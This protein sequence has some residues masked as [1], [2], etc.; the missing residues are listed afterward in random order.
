MNI[1]RLLAIALL[2]TPAAVFSVAQGCATEPLPQDICSWL[3]DD[4]NCYTRFANDVVPQ[5]GYFPPADPSDPLASATGSFASLDDLSVC[6]G[7]QGGQII[8]DPPLDPATFPITQEQ[9]FTILDK[10]AVECGNI[11]YFSDASFTVTINPVDKNDAGT[12]TCPDGTPLGDNILGGAFGVEKEAGRERIDVKCPGGLEQYNFNLL[13]QQTCIERTGDANRKAQLTKAFKDNMPRAELI[14]NRGVPA[15][16]DGPGVSG[17]AR[18]RVYYPPAPANDPTCG[19]ATANAPKAGE[20]RV[21]E[22]FNCL[23]PPPPAPC[24]NMVKD[25]NETDV[26]CGGNCPT[27]CGEGQNC[28]S[29]ND[30][31]SSVGLTCGFVG[32]IQQCKM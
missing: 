8:F 20:P 2:A 1:K 28:N 18:L 31:D 4:N 23:I 15:T 22:Y 27:K 25:G 21:V 3:S 9:S 29:N 17:Y 13:Q 10:K 16:N 12:A 14:T 6:I 5:C 30:C 26:D 19:S 7:N 32:G 11:L 24:S